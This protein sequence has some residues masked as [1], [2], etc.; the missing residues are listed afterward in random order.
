MTGRKRAS[1]RQA[2]NKQTDLVVEKEKA[3][4]K[5]KNLGWFRGGG[6]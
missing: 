2:Q 6:R 4:R 1:T 5:D 3:L